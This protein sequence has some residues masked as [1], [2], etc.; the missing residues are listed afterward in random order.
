MAVG[1]C[2]DSLKI[3]VGIDRWIRIFISIKLEVEE[4]VTFDIIGFHRPAR[5]IFSGFEGGV[6]ID[7][8]VGAVGQ[9]LEPTD[10]GTIENVAVFVQDIKIPGTRKDVAGIGEQCQSGARRPLGVEIVRQ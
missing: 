6:K 2:V 3:Q 10:L 7:S 8:E 4:L 9:V 5:C 1:F